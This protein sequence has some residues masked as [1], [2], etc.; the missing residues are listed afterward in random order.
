MHGLKKS[1]Y[2]FGLII[3]GGVHHFFASDIELSD[4]RYLGNISSHHTTVR[5]S[6]NVPQGRYE[7]LMHSVNQLRVYDEGDESCF[8]PKC[9]GVSLVGTCCVAGIIYGILA[10]VGVA[11]YQ[12]Y[13]INN[14]VH[15]P[16]KLHFRGNSFYCYKTVHHT[17][18][19]GKT[20]TSRVQVDCTKVLY[21]GDRT[22]LRNYGHLTELGAYL[23]DA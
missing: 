13:T 10:G 4:I 22:T 11:D 3:C 8:T 20:T 14:Q 21:P 17:D 23:Y 19:K 1:L 7:A 5:H 6:E 16:I 12:K 15:K 9:A 2:I 18:S